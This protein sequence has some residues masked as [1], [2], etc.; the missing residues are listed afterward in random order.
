LPRHLASRISS[1]PRYHARQ[2]RLGALV[3]L[4]VKLAAVDALDER[5][6]LLRIGRLQIGREVPGHRKRRLLARR[7]D[8]RSLP[9]LVAPDAEWTGVWRDGRAFGAEEPLAHV[10]PAFGELRGA[11]CHL[12][13]IGVVEDRV[14]I[15]VAVTV[16]GGAALPSS[17]G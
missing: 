12:H 5:L 3:R 4:I 14:V 13:V 7:L 15:A 2:R 11:E 1:G 16:I 9:W 17:R 8:Q 6:F 10:P